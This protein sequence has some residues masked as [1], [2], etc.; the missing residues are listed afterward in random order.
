M[1]CAWYRIELLTEAVDAQQADLSCVFVTLSPLLSAI[2][3]AAVLPCANLRLL[4]EI[5]SRD[6][7]GAL[8]GFSRVDLIVVGLGS[9]ESD[10]IAHSI[11]THAPEAKVLLIS[12]SGNYAYFFRSKLDRIVL[13]DFP[14]ASL[15][16]LILD[17]DGANHH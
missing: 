3:A 1:D 6:H 12:G 16:E 7:L 8:A 15:R 17:A 13:F 4:Q 10:D 11:L 5:H 14:P 9:G 2:V